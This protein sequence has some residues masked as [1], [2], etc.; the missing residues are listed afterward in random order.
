MLVNWLVKYSMDLHNG[1]LHIYSLH[2]KFLF[3]QA[4]NVNPNAKI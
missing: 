2:F 4:T 1:S 3:A